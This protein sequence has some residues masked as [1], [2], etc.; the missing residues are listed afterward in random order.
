MNFM[1][2]WY[3]PAMAAA[4]TLPALLLL[5]FLKLKRQRMPV[6]STLLWRKAVEDLR[7]NAPF[8]RLR[9]SLLL[10]LQLLILAAAIFALAE[11][12]KAADRTFEEAIVLLVDQSA[13]MAVEEADGETRLQTAK[14]QAADIVDGLTRDQRAMVVAFAGRA[15]VLVPFTGN[16]NEL[17]AAI[18]SIEQTDIPGALR[19]AVALA[20]AH[21]TPG[22]EEGGGGESLQAHVVLFTD[23]RL[24]DADQVALQ[25]GT[26]EVVRV[27]NASD[28]VGIVDLDVRRS[29]EQPALVT[30]LARVRNFGG[31]PVQRDLS[32][33]VAGQ[34]QQVRSLQLEPAGSPD[35][36]PRMDLDTVPAENS[37]VVVPF[38]M[39]LDGGAVVAVQ[40]AGGDALGADDRAHAV[41]TPPH[42]LRV[43]LVTVGNRFLQR[44]IGVMPLETLDVWTPAEYEAKP[45]AE[46]IEGGRCRY[47]VV[48]FDDH[49]TDRLPAGNYLFF[50]G[51][52]LIEGVERGDLRESEVLL[53]WDDTHPV[54]QHVA[55]ES[56]NVVAWRRL[57]LPSEAYVL[58]DSTAGPVMGYLNRG[59]SQYLICAFGIFDQTRT[60]L[61]T[62]WVFKPDSVAFMYDALRYLAGGTT[63]GQREPVVPG[64]PI[65]LPVA[66]NLES[67]RVTRP[68]GGI[69]T[70]PV[71][72]THVATYGHTGRVGLYEIETGTDDDG[73]RA[74]NLLDEQESFIAP[75]A[76]FRMAAGDVTQTGGSELARRALWPYFLIGLGVILLLEWIVYTRRV[77]V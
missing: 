34:L 44:L 8:Q 35:Q 21:A 49:S 53:D 64:E 40:L 9:S 13:S 4:I 31:R 17:L 2:P 19:E 59:R 3:V 1:S 66:P 38:E 11:P 29:Y 47:D 45:D 27:G 20:E 69:D 50:A 43:L 52:P 70:V 36:L 56:L 73:T 32:L 28:N 39:Q 18:E 33:Y 68:D 14:R 46:L 77:Y 7:V 6:A 60:R 5:Y 51:I 22:G 25:R 76:A 41:V 16:R 65:V 63:V 67:T 12:Y 23:G 62:D 26:I 55:V 15:R 74:V 58:I 42:P 10:L 48:V 37:E 24:A 57:Q 75:N 61:N 71:D 54:L 30:V 72:P